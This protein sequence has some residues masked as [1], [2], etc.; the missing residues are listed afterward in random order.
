MSN[1]VTQDSEDVPNQAAEDVHV[2][3]LRRRTEKIRNQRI[4]DDVR[5]W[6]ERAEEL[7]TEAEF[8]E[9]SLARAALL[10]TAKSYETLATRIEERLGQTASVPNSSKPSLPEPSPQSSGSKPTHHSDVT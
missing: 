2:Q 8:V 7:R 3:D 5:Y 10:D 6:R 4:I 1:S 9:E